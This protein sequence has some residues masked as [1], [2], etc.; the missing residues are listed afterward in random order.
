MADEER[1]GE[2][3]SARHDF[4][5][6]EANLTTLAK[7]LA[8]TINVAN[9]VAAGHNVLRCYLQTQVDAVFPA[10]SHCFGE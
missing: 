1:C 9:P 5:L 4:N 2:V 3:A 7:R 10:S 8:G 6:I